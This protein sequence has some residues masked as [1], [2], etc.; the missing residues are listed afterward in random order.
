MNMAS[1]AV[2]RKARVRIGAVL[3]LGAVAA[4]GRAEDESPLFDIPRL[5][6]IAIDG[7]AEDWG[8]N[9][10][11]VDAMVDSEG[12]A[13]SAGEFSSRF[14][15]GWDE[16]GL[17]ALITVHDPT[18]LE[19]KS[20]DRFWLLDSVELFVADKYGGQERLQG[21]PDVGLSRR[22]GPGRATPA[23]SGNGG[24]V[25]TT[26]RSGAVHALPRRGT[27]FVDGGP[28]DRGTIH[29]AASTA[30]RPA[31][32]TAGK[33]KTVYPVSTVGRAT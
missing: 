6:K 4:P 31:G 28:R 1:I 3:L 2:V 29:L 24:R 14:R 7:K 33:L 17:L 22:Q 20:E 32:E 18:P 5:G 25:E 15:L 30:S 9:G 26:G 12:L 16:R 11:R 27:R 13:R 23:Q 10:F 21:H 19:E 8:P